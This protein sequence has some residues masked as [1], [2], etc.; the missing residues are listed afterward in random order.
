MAKRYEYVFKKFKSGKNLDKPYCNVI[1]VKTGKIVKR[2]SSKK[3][4]KSAHASVNRQ[5]RSAE[6]EEMYTYIDQQTRLYGGDAK[7][8]KTQYKR[9]WRVSERRAKKKVKADIKAGKKRVQK[10]GDKKRKAI[11]LSIAKELTSLSGYL[12]IFREYWVFAEDDD[13]PQLMQGAG[14]W[15]GD[16]FAEACEMV[17]DNSDSIRREARG[18]KRFEIYPESG[19]CVRLIDRADGRLLDKYGLGAGCSHY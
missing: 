17:R 2:I 16:H 5:K 13:S 9:D 10:V 11:K 6:D 7:K 14:T 8:I 4:L 1:S 15:E 18:N 12:T 3:Q 19:A